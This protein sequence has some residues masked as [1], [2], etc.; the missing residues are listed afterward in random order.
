MR[1]LQWDRR[2][3]LGRCPWCALV[4]TVLGSGLTCPASA[5]GCRLALN[6]GLAWSS[7]GVAN[8]TSLRLA[9]QLR[10]YQ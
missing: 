7:G 9:F 3:G 6:A 1:R 4:L 2:L 5:A 8:A 10:L